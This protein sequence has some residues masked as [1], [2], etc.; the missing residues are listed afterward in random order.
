MAIPAAN[1]LDRARQHMRMLLAIESLIG[2]RS[3]YNLSADQIDDLRDRERRLAGDILA[4]LRRLS[5]IV[6]LPVEAPGTG[7]PV[8][9][10]WVDLRAQPLSGEKIQERVLQR[11]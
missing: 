8:G 11:R 4:S 5:D 10:E 2:A 1:I 3:R 6:A 7:D 9:I